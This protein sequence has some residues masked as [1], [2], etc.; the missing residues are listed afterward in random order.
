[1]YNTRTLTVDEV[2]PGSAADDAGIVAGDSIARIA[3]VAV[4]SA[5]EIG[6]ALSVLGTKYRRTEFEIVMHEAPVEVRDPPLT[7]APRTRCL[8]PPSPP[9]SPQRQRRRTTAAAA[10]GAAAAVT[11]V[12][13]RLG[14]ARRAPA[15]RPRRAR[16]VHMT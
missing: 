2:I 8:S 9:S 13:N 15:R 6:A 3:G 5:A 10:V 14:R 1:M 4:T 16:A 11:A 7:R 12:C